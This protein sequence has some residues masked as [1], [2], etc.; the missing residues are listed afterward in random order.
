MNGHIRTILAEHGGLGPAVGGLSDE[1]DLY[2]FGLNSRAT[3]NVMLALE[4]ALGI[5]FSDQMLSRGMFASIAS[6]REAVLRVGLPE[7]RA[8]QN[9]S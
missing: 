9:P 6:I 1:S 8:P 4:G 2:S 3:V 7:A 5:E